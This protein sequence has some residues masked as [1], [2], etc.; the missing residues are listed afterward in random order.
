MEIWNGDTNIIY[1]KMNRSVLDLSGSESQT[2][3]VVITYIEIYHPYTGVC[4]LIK[5]PIAEVNPSSVP[6][7]V[8]YII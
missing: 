6:Y 7:H 8:I 2:E 4:G 5:C 3:Y 1:R